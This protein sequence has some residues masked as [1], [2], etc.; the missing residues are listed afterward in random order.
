MNVNGV[1]I[2]G[3]RLELM[4]KNMSVKKKELFQNEQQANYVG[5]LLKD[6]NNV[7]SYCNF[8]FYYVIRFCFFIL[9][10]CKR[11]CL[12][13]LSVLAKNRLLENF[14]ILG[15]N[16]AQDAYLQSLIKP[17]SVKQHKEKSNKQQHFSFTYVVIN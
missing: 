3:K 16:I 13:K 15:S 8:G 12:E 2:K 14:N 10:R 11:G 4:D 9:F 7:L 5:K 17:Q 6:L 1:T